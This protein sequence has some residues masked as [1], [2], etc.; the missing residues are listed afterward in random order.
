[1]YAHY[2]QTPTNATGARSAFDSVQSATNGP[3]TANTLNLPFLA[4]LLGQQTGLLTPNLLAQT[5]LQQIGNAQRSNA[6]LLQ[7]M[8]ADAALEAR[9]PQVRESYRS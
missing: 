1:M 5:L 2:L 8:K 7:P 6:N 4:P 3:A 9:M